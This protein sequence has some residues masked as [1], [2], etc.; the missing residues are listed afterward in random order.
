MPKQYGEYT[1]LPGSKSGG[2]SVA[3]PNRTTLW[4]GRDHL[5]Y[6]LNQ[7]YTEEYK[8][9]YYRNIQA[10]V[11]H[12]TRTG[13]VWNVI[14]GY[15]AAN[16]LA[17]VLLSFLLRWH[18]GWAIAFGIH[19]AVFAFAL[20]VNWRR[21]PTCRT[22]L[23][24]AV[25]VIRLYSL[26][27][28][29]LARRAIA[30]IRE[31]VEAEQGTAA[32]AEPPAAPEDAAANSTVADSAPPAAWHATALAPAEPLRHD[33]GRAHEI[34]FLVLLADLCHSIVRFYTGGTVMYVFGLLLMLAV[35][36]ALIVA[37]IRQ[38]GTDLPRPVK[39]MTWWTLG[40]FI[41]A[42]MV[43][44]G[45]SIA[46]SIEHPE[47]SGNSVELS[48]ALFDVSPRQSLFHFFDILFS[49]GFNGIVG[50]LGL[51]K[52]SVFRRTVAAPPPLASAAPTMPP[53]PQ[54]PA[55]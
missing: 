15:L 48:R 51:W 13:F 24:T 21:G 6:V 4:L 3:L 19:A 52:L 49:I 53:P 26:N 54:T 43:S 44:S 5:L 29:P 14:W 1:R 12:K 18:I 25:Q 55:G 11:F 16:C 34:L 46:Y 41:L 9:L 17:F 23:Q 2:F 50:F 30:Q 40:Y 39:L 20:L 35:M 27:R 10:I 28:V 38:H 36:A 7:G 22:Y 33:R 8:R 32:P 31:R 37:I 47:L 42:N 45:Y